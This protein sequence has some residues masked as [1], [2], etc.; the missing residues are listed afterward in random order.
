MK[1]P[2]TVEQFFGVFRDYN[3]SVWPA[4]VL[5]VALAVAA[6]ILVIAPQRWSGVTISSILA[7]LWAWM[8]L[9]YHLAFFSSIN[10]LAYA[11]AALSL[12]AAA[13]FFWQ[14]VVRRRLAFRLTAGARTAVGLGLVF[15]S[16][17]L[18]PLW[19]FYAGHH[20]PALPTF[21]LPCPTTLFTIGLL[22]FLVAPYPRSPFVV[23]VLWCFVGA[24]AA[25][26]FDV[27]QDLGLVVAGV[28]GIVLLLRSEVAAPRV[29]LPS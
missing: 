24:Q 16:L 10:P 2:F 27:P 11:F 20:Y 6:L 23:P 5:L 17:V 21:G 14:G 26:L 28:A 18:Y 15:F 8:A 1:I 9:A 13:V 19:S 29:G 12:A 22:A 4:Q 7:F 3:L 25:F